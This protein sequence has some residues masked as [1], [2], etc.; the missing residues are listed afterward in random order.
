MDGR[1]I[2]AKPIGDAG[3]RDLITELPGPRPRGTRGSETERPGGDDRTARA[4]RP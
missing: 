1:A 2:S 3:L 4:T